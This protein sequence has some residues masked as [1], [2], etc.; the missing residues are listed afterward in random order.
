MRGDGRLRDIGRGESIK[1]FN[2]PWIIVISGFVISSTTCGVGYSF[3][4]FFTSFKATLGQNSTIVSGAYSLSLFMF[5]VFGIFAGFGVDRYGPR[6]ITILGGLLLSLGLFLTSEVTSIWEL[7]ITYAL[8]GIGMSPAYAPMMTTVSRW[9]SKHRGFALGIISAGVGAGP[10]IV[11]PLATYLISIHGW[12]LTLRLLAF[13]PI[14]VIASAMLLKKFPNQE[15]ALAGFLNETT[16]QQPNLRGEPLR[17]K[18]SGLLVKDAIRRKAFWQ[19]SIMFMMIGMTV[20]MM[21]AHIVAYSTSQGLSP[22]QASMILGT[23]SSSSIPGRIMM[24]FL[25]D[26]FGRRISLAIC[27]FTEGIMLLWLLGISNVWT[28]FLFAIIYGLSY[29]GHASQMPALTVDLFG[30]E[31]LGSIIGLT[32]FFW[33]TGAALGPFVAGYIFD[34]TGNYSVAFIMA[35]LAMF[36][37]TTL[38]FF[39]KKPQGIA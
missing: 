23:I 11:A 17:K 7:Y 25:S 8:I 30:L 28:F 36:F 34:F 14:L 6:M 9:I 27:V 13:I 20:Q 33:G 29:G 35:A 31:H 3:G 10:L 15:V 5:S 16:V 26:R 1:R 32:T 2:Y 21:M 18:F 22:M 37:T 39:L 4:V 19:L 24:G 12:R 38:T